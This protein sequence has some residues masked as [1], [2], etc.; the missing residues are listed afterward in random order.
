MNI[1]KIV[2]VFDTIEFHRLM[3][4]KILRCGLLKVDSYL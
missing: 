1:K 2:S 4:V 3:F